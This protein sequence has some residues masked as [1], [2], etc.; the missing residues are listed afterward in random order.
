MSGDLT[1]GVTWQ[2]HPTFTSDHYTILT[3]LAVA[4]PVPPRPPPR[5]DIRRADWAMFQ[6]VLGEWWTAYE[7][8]G[9]LHQQESNLT[10]TTHKPA[11]GTIPRT[12]PSR[13][14]RP[15]WWFYSKQVREH[16][17]HVNIHRKLYKKRPNLTTLRL[18]QEV[19]NCA[20]GISASQGGKMAAVMCHLQPAHLPGLAVEECAYRHGCRP[21]PPSNSPTS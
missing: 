2:V 12:S 6:S 16:N 19:V 5:W 10:A 20:G 14:H 3:I 11:D 4:P 9:D 7:P 18:L 17:H 8:P 21:S 1:P 13:C 15:D